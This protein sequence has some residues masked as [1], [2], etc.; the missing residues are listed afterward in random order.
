VAEKGGYPLHHPAKRRMA[1]LG[2]DGIFNTFILIAVTM[3]VRMGSIAAMR[4]K[5]HNKGE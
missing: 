4:S 3:Y 2:G 1:S 5:K